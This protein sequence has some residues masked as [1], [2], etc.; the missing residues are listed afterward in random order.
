M[1][2]LS[3]FLELSVCR[4]NKEDGVCDRSK[5]GSVKGLYK[6]TDQKRTDYKDMFNLKVIFWK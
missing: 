4:N 2:F 5:G 3:V 6:G 1:R